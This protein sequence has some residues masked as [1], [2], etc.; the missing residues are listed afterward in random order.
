MSQAGIVDIEGSHPQIPTLFVCNVGTAIPIANTLEILGTTVAAHSVPLETI[1]S[2]NTVTITAQYASAAA[3]SVATNAGF[4]S[5]NSADFTVDANGYVTFTG[6]TGTEGFNVDA[7]TAP[8]TN[9]VEPD[10]SNNVTVTGGQVAAGTTS[11]VIRTN[12][13]AANTYTIQI[14]RSQAVASSTIGDNGVSHFN[15][16]FFTVDGN[17][18]VSLNGSAVGETITGNVGGALSPTAG[19]WNIFGTS[20][21]AGTTPVQTSGSGSTLTVQVQ[22][23]QAIAASDATK[24]GLSNF[25]SSDFSVDANGFVSASA[26][27]YIRTIT[28]TSGGAESPASGGNFNILGATALAGTTPVVVAGSTNTETVKVQI[29]QA[30]ASTDATKVGLAAFDSADFTV[31]ANG[32]VSGSGTGFI[33]TITGNSGGAEGPSSGNFNILGTGSITVAGSANTETVQLTGL[34]THNVLVGAGSA[35]ITKVAPSATSG[36]PLISQGSSSDPSFGTAVVAGGGTGDTSFTAYSVICGGTTST[37]ALQNVSGVGTSGQVL[38]SNGAGT[39][40][41]WQAAGGGSGV[42]ITGDVGSITGTSLT[43]YTASNCGGSV[44]F[45]NSGTTSILKVTDGSGNT[46]IGGSCGNN[47]LSG[48]TNVGLGTLAGSGLTTGAQNTLLGNSAGGAIQTGAGN[49]CVGY[50][51]GSSINIGSSNIVLGGN[52]PTSGTSNIVIGLSASCLSG[53]TNNVMVGDTAGGSVASANNMVC[54]ASPGGS[55]AQD[56]VIEIGKNSTHTACLIQGIDGVTISGSA[57]LINS[58]GQLGD[59]VSSERF[60]KDIQVIPP[61]K[62]LELQP[63]AFKYKKES[64]DRFHFGLIAEEVHKIFPELV[65]YDKEKKPYS[66]MY[67]EMPVLLLAEIQ[68]LRKELDELKLKISA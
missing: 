51:A 10:G 24:I 7:S 41:T 18:F 67:H 12:S 14:Q 66:V 45:S 22:K 34:T 47:T 4:A 65:L 31:D 2:G 63:V 42:T 44:L 21:A 29:T 17:G 9:P 39:L 46:F 27:G 43:I 68:K 3:S 30:I 28:G 58:S 23:S 40:P 16:A 54:I 20:T 35:T 55:L 33:K 26:T 62:I 61:N 36:V 60:K 19:N 57:V 25:N 52:G 32:F 64:Q 37:G 5:F 6:S 59:V 38:T 15:S 50:N 53:A 13:L 56:G 1:G 11:N 48:G 49:I 8:G